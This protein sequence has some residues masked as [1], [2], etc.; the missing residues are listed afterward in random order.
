MLKW[1]FGSKDQ[2][3][4]QKSGPVSKAQRIDRR[5]QRGRLGGVVHVPELGLIGSHSQSPNGRYVL[6]WR[7]GDDAGTSGGA[8]QSGH[9]RYYLV[10]GD[11]VVAEGRAERP[12]DGKVADNGTFIIND[13]HFFT[14]ELRG[15]FMA[16][17]ADGSPIIARRFAA[18]LFNNGLAENGGLAV[19][20]T[21]NAPNDDSSRL[22][23]F[24]LDAGREVGGCIPES[25][26]ASEYAFPGGSR[27]SLVYRDLG[28]FDYATDGTFLDRERW[29]EASL[30]RGAP[31]LIQTLL[32][33]AGDTPS[34]ALLQR[35]I[36][37]TDAAL[38][39]PDY[40]DARWQAQTF[41]HRG[42]CLD[43]LGRQKEA[44]ASFEKALALDP[45]IGV[46]RRI[47]QLRKLTS[48]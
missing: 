26:W 17:R 45:K 43:G 29:I 46:K 34:P 25:G 27:V 41:K 11:C 20:Q 12:N 24:D 47:E 31:Y 30:L 35:L 7:D 23:I 8:R 2:S 18:N 13:W 1:L 4:A 10:D 6:L 40:G 37:A 19:C 5:F 48:T 44:L 32:R 22:T 9:G 36:V 33:D 38:Q 16:F 15:T 39:N 42:V 21:A 14:G 3:A 28:G